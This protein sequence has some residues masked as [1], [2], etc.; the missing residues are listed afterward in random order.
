VRLPPATAPNSRAWAL[1]LGRS[2][3]L[4]ATCDL[5]GWGAAAAD[6]ALALA[7]ES[8]A[9]VSEDPA[10]CLPPRLRRPT[11]SAF[12]LR[13]RRLGLALGVRRSTCA[14]AST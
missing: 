13:F 6:L 7:R 5:V 14:S 12:F 10:R 2:W 1:L 8:A 11:Y 9:A 4:A 3:P